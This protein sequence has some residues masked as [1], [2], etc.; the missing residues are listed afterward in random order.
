MRQ[1]IYYHDGV[2]KT[3]VA[4]LLIYIFSFGFD[5]FMTMMG[6]NA[7]GGFEYEGNPVL[8]SAVLDK[9]IYL[10]FA[11]FASQL[12]VFYLAYGIFKIRKREFIVEKT[13]TMKFLFWKIHLEK[14]YRHAFWKNRIENFTLATV[15]III[16]VSPIIGHILLGGLSWYNI[17]F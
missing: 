1:I 4:F 2:P 15:K 12:L 3:F 17:I 10:M 14:R 7:L 16:L 13:R 8:R 6:T 5:I 9:N 11:Y